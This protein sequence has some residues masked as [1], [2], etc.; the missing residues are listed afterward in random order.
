MRRLWG[1]ALTIAIC[2]LLVGPWLVQAQA[3]R[4]PPQR[5]LIVDPTG[6]HVVTVLSSGHLATS[7]SVT[8]DN[9]GH[10]GS[11]THVAGN[12]VLRN[13]AGTAVTVTG[14]ALD[15]NCTGCAA[16]SVVGVTHVSGALHIA[17]TIKGAQ[18]HIQGLGIPGQAHG[19]VLTIQGVTGGVPVPI[20][21][22]ITA[23]DSV[24]VFHQSTI[25]HISS[26]TH[27]YVVDLPRSAHLAAA[28]SGVWSMTAHQGG[29]WTIAHLSSAVHVA[30]TVLVNCVTGCSASTSDT[31]NVFHQSTIR[32]ISSVTHI[33]SVG[34]LG[35]D[36]HQAGSWTVAATQSGAFNVSA[37]QSGIWNIAGAHI[38]GGSGHLAVTM[39]DHFVVRIPS[40][41]AITQSAALNVSAAQ[42]GSFTVQAAHQGGNWNIAHISSQTHIVGSGNFG[43]L[44]ISGLSNIG[45]GSPGGN[46]TP[47]ACHTTVAFSTT[48]SLVLAHSQNSMRIF[49]CSIVMVAA[50]AENLSIVEGTGA[51][52]ATGTRGVIGGFGGTMSVAATGGFSSIA[53][54]P[55]ISSSVAGNQVCLSKSGSG[56]VS[57][58]ITYRGAP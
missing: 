57:G 29:G 33:Q 11:V 32:H 10:I 20:S 12:V 18:F 51:A 36:A 8:V 24:N 7:A 39:A 26:V 45:S 14:T 3:P 6:T 5:V 43:S 17:G 41:V 30:G 31:V 40:H 25:R 46:T 13:V 53:A 4:T 54:F 52:C 23:G 2:S 58:A 15:V 37:A 38:V 42:S 50:A 21:G 16:A 49:I 56:N 19:G 47:M 27:V 35:V 28:Q 48:A 55:W 44:H 22:T 1:V 34:R 9:I